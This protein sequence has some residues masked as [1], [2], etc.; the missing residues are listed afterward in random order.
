[1]KKA[2]FVLYDDF[3]NG[4]LFLNSF[5]AINIKAIKCGDNLVKP[6]LKVNL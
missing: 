3:V 5:K 1:M 6:Y 2:L 4:L